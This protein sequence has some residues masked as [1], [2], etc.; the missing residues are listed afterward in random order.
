MPLALH[1][2]VNGDTK[3]AGNVSVGTIRVA[4]AQ[5]DQPLLARHP[6]AAKQAHYL[7]PYVHA[8]A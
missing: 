2:L 8:Q 1:D 3:R 5:Q 6:V 4:T 7:P